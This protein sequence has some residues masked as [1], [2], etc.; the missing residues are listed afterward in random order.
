MA[1][2]INAGQISANPQAAPRAKK[3]DPVVTAT[4]TSI[5]GRFVL[6]ARQNHFIADATVPRGGA[7]DAPG[8]AEYFLSG[9][10]TCALAVIADTAR[11][12]GI[13]A[14][15]TA[16]GSYTQDPDDITRFTRVALTFRCHGASQAQA[17]ELVAE[18]RRVCPIYNTV[19]RAAPVIVTAIGAPVP[20]TEIG[21]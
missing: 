6:D 11:L 4:S 20:G 9:L 1:D 15:Y 8:A 18:F 12:R 7:G 2:Q 3:P 13:D 14:S 19:A 5:Q 10:L 17:E 21:A 16:E